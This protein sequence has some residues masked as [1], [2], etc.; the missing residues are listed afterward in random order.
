MAALAPQYLKNDGTL[1]FAAASTSDTV[2]IGSGRDTFLVYKNSNGSPVVVTVVVPGKS[3][4]GAELPDNAVT[5]PANG[6]AF[7]P[8]RREY[9]NEEGRATVT[10]T[11]A[12]GMTVAVAKVA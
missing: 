6:T 8:V 1:N 11:S 4:L 7:I 3:F 5:V 12:T 10:M 9:A 2:P